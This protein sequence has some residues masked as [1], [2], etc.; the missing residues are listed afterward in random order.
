[1]LAKRYALIG[2]IAG[3][4][5]SFLVPFALIKWRVYSDVAWIVLALGWI[6]FSPGRSDLF[7]I[8]LATLFDIG[9]YGVVFVLVVQMSMV[10][11]RLLFTKH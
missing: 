2:L 6:I 3:A 11:R 10:I 5:F 4:L 7:E 9:F 8:A 1:L